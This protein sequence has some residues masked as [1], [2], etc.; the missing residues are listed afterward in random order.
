MTGRFWG[1]AL[2]NAAGYVLCVLA[3][4][5]LAG[6]AAAEL[7]NLIY[8]SLS[9][10]RRFDPTAALN[11]YASNWFLFNMISG[12]A[13]GFTVYAAWRHKAALFV[14]LP[15]ACLLCEK[16]L[17]HPHSLMEAGWSGARYFLSTGCS[18]ISLRSLYIS[19]RCADQFHYSLPFYAALSFSVGALLS[20]LYREHTD[21]AG[22]SG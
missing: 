14:W 9:L 8:R 6:F 12:I 16:I 19:Q 11:F 2:A 10:F 15:A 5:Y 7:S 3:S 4:M 13:F 17:T 18:E 20:M 1:Q 22:G 21:R